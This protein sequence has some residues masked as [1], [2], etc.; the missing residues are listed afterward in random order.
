MTI[1]IAGG[2]TAGHVT[3]GLAVADALVARGHP[4]GS[5]QFV[6][7][8]GRIEERLV[9]EAGYPLT[10]LPGRGLDRRLSLANVAALWGLARAAIGAWRLMRRTRPTV[11]LSVGG[12]AS[13][14][15]VLAAAVRRIPVVAMEQNA[16]PGAVSRFAARVAKVTAVSFPGTALSRAVVTGNP[17]RSSIVTADR[18]RDRARAALGLPGHRHLVFV[19]GGSLGAARINEAVTGLVDKWSDRSD[20]AVR[21][22]CGPRNFD[23][24]AARAPSAADGGLVHQLVAFENRVADALVAADVAVSRAGSGSIAELAALGVPAVLVPWAGAAEDHQR[25]NA[26]IVAEAGAAVVVP[27]DELTTARLADLLDELLGDDERRARLSA[28]AI[29]FARP[30]AAEAVADLVEQYARPAKGAR[31]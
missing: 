29:A 24:L 7:S 31:R 17:I 8:D 19:W 15:C 26:A 18:D 3:P 30:R 21:H 16:R 22:V 2:G 28:A 5:I 9:P 1:V 13:A 4:A 12:Y 6:G 10:L 27:D 14:A 25:A 23:E 20:V 11:V